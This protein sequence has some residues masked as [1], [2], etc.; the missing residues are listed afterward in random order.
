MVTSSIAPTEDSV[1]MVRILLAV[2]T[3]L[4]T[5]SNLSEK[6]VELSLTTLN[7]S[8]TLNA[9]RSAAFGVAI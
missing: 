7:G 9:R 8:V 2:L 6:G 5:T 3:S 1:E 4:T